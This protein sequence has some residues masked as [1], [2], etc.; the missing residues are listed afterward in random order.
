MVQEG[1]Q[2]TTNH[3][4]SPPKRGLSL[5]LTSHRQSYN[6]KCKPKQFTNEIL[7][8][9]W[10][11]S[12]HSAHNTENFSDWLIFQ[13]Q[14]FS[15]VTAL[16]SIS[17]SLYDFSQQ[18]FSLQY[19]SHTHTYIYIYVM[20]LTFCWRI[21][22]HTILKVQYNKKRNTKPRSMQSFRNCVATK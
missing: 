12:A 18:D 14:A 4:I 13:N 2:N 21:F 22:K 6:P 1:T 8:F 19:P 7:S 10:D 3:S 9:C 20:H 11:G 16:M 17:Q 5:T 15:L